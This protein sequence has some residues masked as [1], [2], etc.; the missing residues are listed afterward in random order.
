MVRFP[1]LALALLT[2][3]PL[4]TRSAGALGDGKAW[5]QR[6]SYFS[7]GF[8][9]VN[10]NNLA[11]EP[12]RFVLRGKPLGIDLIVLTGLSHTLMRL[13]PDGK[14]RWL[15]D[16]SAGGGAYGLSKIDGLIAICF[17]PDI[18]LVNPQDGEVVHRFPV[19]EPGIGQA[20]SFLR[21]QGYTLLTAESRE[22]GDLIIADFVRD[23]QG[24]LTGLKVRERIPTRMEA[25]RDA[26]LI[27]DDKLLVVDTFGHAVALYERRAAWRERRR[28]AEYFPNMLDWQDGE[29]IVLAEHANRLA[30]W[31]LQ[32]NQRRLLLACPHPLFTDW[33][34]SPRQVKTEEPKTRTG[35][36]PPRQVC[37]T[38]IAGDQSLYAP[39]GFF[40]EGNGRLWVADADNHRV[41]LFVDGA[42]WGAITGI[43]HPV[44]ILPFPSAAASAKPSK[45]IPTSR[46]RWLGH[47]RQDR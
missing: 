28:W 9:T 18:L 32:R 30:S 45:R 40:D 33:R 46:E 38:D 44:R 42:F 22:H 15:L 12:K 43:N 21:V 3:M 20:L 47:P 39:N 4:P 25:P 6:D 10:L 41:A 5:P 14:P 23:R 8:G 29:L 7:P 24:R 19:L 27:A 31:D 26:L 17:G 34:T 13:A 36:S 1:A 16:V 2:L 35:E 37:V 11:I